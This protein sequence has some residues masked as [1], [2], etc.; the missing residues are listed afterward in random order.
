[1]AESKPSAA[2]VGC[3]GLVGSQILHALLSHP[4][5]PH[6]H[7]LTRRAL[8]QTSPNLSVIANP[9][10]T[11]WPNALKSLS[12]APKIL[13]SALGTTRAAA[14]S[15]AAQ[16]AIDYDLNLCLA[17]A[18]KES[19]T[20][21]YVLIS[22]AGVS[23]GSPFPYAKMKAELEEAVKKL[24]FPYTVI[25]KPGLLVGTRQD[26]R[27]AEAVLRYVAKGLRMVSKELLTEWWAQD[28]DVI[29]RAAARAGWECLE[30][31]REK[32]VWMLGQGDIVKMGKELK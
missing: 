2:L 15:F 26:S 24:E 28:V 30:G 29:G 23:L 4:S 20:Q 14:G 18:A 12:P 16:R 3:T 7:A 6:I 10:T 1:M 31:T 27:P 22:S 11:A 25:V 17:Q 5:S 19:G 13:L 21:V 32:G 8:P 9:D